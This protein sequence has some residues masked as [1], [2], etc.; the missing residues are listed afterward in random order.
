M[1]DPTEGQQLALLPAERLGGQVAMVEVSRVYFE[2]Q[3]ITPEFRQSIA[4]N[5]ILQPVAL[6]RL[7]SQEAAEGTLFRVAAG[8]RRLTACQEVGI[9]VVPALIFPEGTPRH[10]AAAISLMENTQRGPNPI[11]EYH[12]IREMID[13]GASEQDI[14]DQ[15][16]LSPAVVRRRLS[17][18]RLSAAL[19]AALREGRMAVTVAERVARLPL[20]R[21]EPLSTLAAR[22]GM[23]R[24]SDY[25][26]VRAQIE[27]DTRQAQSEIPGTEETRVPLAGEVSNMGTDLLGRRFIVVDGVRWIREDMT[28]AAN[29]ESPTPLTFSIEDLE[30]METWEAVHVLLEA[31]QRTLPVEA[32]D[33]VDDVMLQI[34]NALAMVV[35]ARDGGESTARR[36]VQ[37]GATTTAPGATAGF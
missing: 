19:F 25:N 28:Q 37:R 27:Q 30:G 21:Q 22:G 10:L 7:T 26:A 17:L 8:R 29:P 1:R 23:V 24:V 6:I 5:G 36:S 35:I 11:N 14:I 18:G 2:T 3:E 31:A 15:L 16:R 4:D 33:E 9:D 12:A 13:A 20:T 32:S 34:S